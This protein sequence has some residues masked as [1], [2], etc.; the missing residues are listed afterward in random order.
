LIGSAN[1]LLAP[2]FTEGF[3]LPVAE[4]MAVGTPV[5]ASDIA[6]HRELASGAR[7]IDPLD[8]PSW[9]AAI[10]A[11]SEERPLVHPAQPMSW[12]GHFAI[13]KDALGW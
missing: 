2:S 10:T 8:G 4:A 9:L 11:A 1:A 6:V 13:V 7:L 5:I 3:N 12:P